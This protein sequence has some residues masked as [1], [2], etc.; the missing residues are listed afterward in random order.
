MRG[1]FILS[2]GALLAVSGAADAQRVVANGPG[3][4]YGMPGRAPMQPPRMQPPHAQP[5]HAQPSHVQPPHMQ[6]RPNMPVVH[7]MPGRAPMMGQGGGRW[8]SKVGGRWWG[9]TNAPGGWNAYRRPVRGYVLPTYWYAPRFFI[10]DWQSYGFRA[11]AQGYSWVR[12]YDDAVLVDG[13]GSVYDTVGGVDWDRYDGAYGDGGYA[14]DGYYADGDEGYRERRDDGLGGAAI[15]A[16]AGGVA[17]NLI[18]GRGNRL[19]GTLIGAG[20]GAAAG[21]AID[22]NEDRGRGDR[23]RGRAPL[24]P[25]APD[26]GPGPGAGYAPPPPPPPMAHGYAAG[27]PGWVSP[28]GRTTVVTTGGGWGGSTTTVVVQ[29]APIVTTTVTEEVIED[30]VTYTRR[31]TK[32][33]KRWRKPACRCK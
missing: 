31:P 33:V 16:V 9:G 6:P 24:P 4:S 14:G 7:P 29:S 17:G 26:Y 12:Y 21:Y 30:R 25:V 13:R 32:I 27:G 3:A 22:K 11:P 1:V 2:A 8:G 28:D 23:G 5:P 20:V 18:A 15:G 19:G 10:N